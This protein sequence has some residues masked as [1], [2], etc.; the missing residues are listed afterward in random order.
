MSSFL[1]QNNNESK[2]RKNDKNGL[3]CND[4]DDEVKIVAKCSAFTLRI[5]HIN[6]ELAVPPVKKKSLIF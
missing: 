2:E 5:Y 6:N 4:E 3:L 1:A